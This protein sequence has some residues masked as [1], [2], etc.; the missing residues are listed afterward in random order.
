MLDVNVMTNL[1]SSV[2]N[3]QVKKKKLKCYFCEKRIC[4][5]CARSFYFIS[6]EKNFVHLF[7]N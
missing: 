5:L 2:N 7:E 1:H 6:S 3:F 4:W